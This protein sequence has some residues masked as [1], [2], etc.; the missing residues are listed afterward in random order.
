[1][2][3]AGKREYV[4]V[5]RLLEVFPARGRARGGAQ[6]RPSGWGAIGF[7]AAKHLVLCRIERR[8]PKPRPD[9]L[10][11]PATG[12]RRD[13]HGRATYLD[14]LG[15]RR[16]HERDARRFCSPITSRRSSCRRSCASTTRL[17]ASVPPRASIMSAYL[18]RLAELETDRAGTADGRAADQGGALFPAVKSLDSFDFLA[19]PSLE[20]DPGA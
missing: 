11:L 6:R 1:M 3:K 2:G 15:G 7:D 9:D 5:L 19:L 18:L 20:Q 4:Q 12:H 13:D 16:R 8:P 10:S 14:L 17:R